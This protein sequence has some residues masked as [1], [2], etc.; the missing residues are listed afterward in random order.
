[1]VF[2]CILI[3]FIIFAYLADIPDY[4]NWILCI[5]FFENKYKISVL[6]FYRSIYKD[7]NHKYLYL[8]HFLS[9]N[10]MYIPWPCDDI[11]KYKRTY[12]RKYYNN[13]LS[14]E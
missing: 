5:K 11:M 13:N 4:Q 6:I 7:W 8:Y 3:Q 12:P 14:E 10:F 2:N 1:M 9:K